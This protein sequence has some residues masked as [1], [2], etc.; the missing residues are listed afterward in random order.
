MVYRPERWDATKTLN[1][2]LD[3]F[4]PF[5]AKPVMCVARRRPGDGKLPFGVS[6]VASLVGA[7]SAEMAGKWEVMGNLP[8]SAVPLDTDREAYGGLVLKRLRSIEVGAGEAAGVND[9][10][11]ER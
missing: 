3:H 11:A 7:I 8:E 10:A 1:W 2:E 9:A 6:M 5:G 4:M